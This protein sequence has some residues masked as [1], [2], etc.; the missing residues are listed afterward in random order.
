MSRPPLRIGG[1]EGFANPPV[2]AGQGQG[3]KFHDGLCYDE[4]YAKVY[5]PLVQPAARAAAETKV[6]IEF[7]E[8]IG[9]PK[10]TLRIG[11]IGCG[12]GVH[13]EL[14]AREGVA[15]VVGY[16]RSPSM[17][18]RAKELYPTREFVVGDASNPK[19]AAAGQFDVL[20]SFYF[21]I[22]MMPNRAQ[23]LR[24]LYLWLAPGGVFFCHVVNKHKFDPVL[25]SASPFVGFSVQKY[26]D[27]RIT[28]SNVTFEEFEYKGDFQISG[29]RAV[30]EEVFNFKNGEV[31][32][33][34]Q[35]LWMPDIDVL[36]SEI[37]GVGFKYTEH[38]DLTAIGYEYNYIFV[39][40]K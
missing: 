20:T 26:S 7:M 39:F 33:H 36:V 38:Q 27:E 12:T 34:E 8:K 1:L 6:V 35:Q 40:Q 17:I 25:E 5:D 9:H 37:E 14:F 21:T 2:G 31:R 24:N 15:S 18:V 23:L 3:Q 11:D 22:Y 16:D 28:Q 10:S 29:S 13:V 19:M 4:F 30:Y 32:Q